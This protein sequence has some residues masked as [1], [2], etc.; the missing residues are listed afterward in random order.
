MGKI[1]VR[2]DAQLQIAV[3]NTTHTRYRV[4]DNKLVNLD[5][6]GQDDKWG[7]GF[8]MQDNQVFSW[9]KL[10]PDIGSETLME[11]VN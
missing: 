9:M 2:V 5:V 7:G 4:V 3:G 1:L 11:E 10:N 8:S 6:P